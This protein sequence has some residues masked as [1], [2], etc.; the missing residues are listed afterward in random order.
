MT[1]KIK[2]EILLGFNDLSFDKQEEIRNAIAESI[3]ADPDLMKEITNEQNNE[4]IEQSLE[5]RKKLTVKDLVELK[6]DEIAMKHETDFR[7]YVT[8]ETEIK[9]I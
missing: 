4:W 9:E 3:K 2:H 5:Y 1:M 6:I 7:S 8:F